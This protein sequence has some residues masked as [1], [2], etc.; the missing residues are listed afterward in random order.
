MT[1]SPMAC[2]LEDTVFFLA[3]CVYY[4]RFLVTVDVINYPG[5]E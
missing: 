5:Q 1:E 3:V 2:L 4:Y